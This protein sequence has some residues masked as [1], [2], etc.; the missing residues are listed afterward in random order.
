M[1]T[2]KDLKKQEQFIREPERE[3]PLERGNFIGMIAAGVLIVLGFVLMLGGSSTVDAFNP[4]IFST[5]RIVVGPL[6]ALLGFIAMGV[7]IIIDP[8]RFSRHKK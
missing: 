5:R 7:A 6:I 2:D 8:S 1:A 3:L 4:D